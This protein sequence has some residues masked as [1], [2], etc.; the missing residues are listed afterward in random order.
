MILIAL[1]S[2]VLYP[3]M[4]LLPAYLMTGLFVRSR[5]IRFIGYSIAN[6]L[7]LAYLSFQILFLMGQ[8]ITVWHPLSVSLTLFVVGVLV[9]RWRKIP[10]PRLTKTNWQVLVVV[11]LIFIISLVNCD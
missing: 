10:V 9:Y 4:F 8:M 11:G 1:Q 3:F 5:G 2:V 7:L 6:S